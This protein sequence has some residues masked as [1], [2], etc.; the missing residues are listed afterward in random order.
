MAGETALERHT[1]VIHGDHAE[2]RLE[3]GRLTMTKGSATQA[4]PTEVTVPV[5]RVRGVTLEAPSRGAPGWLHVSVVGGSPPPPTSLAA[6]GDPYTVP[7]G[8]RATGPAKRLVRMVQRHVRARGLPPEA[9]S[10]GR[11]SGV[12]LDPQG[13]LTVKSTPAEVAE[14]PLSSLGHASQTDR[15]EF[16]QQL[17]ELA[18]LH[19]TGALTDE[20]FRRAKQRLIGP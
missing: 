20:E 3:D 16:V 4:T 17:G 12:V 14:G 13:P 5:E 10:V 2:L 18:D 9:P 19:A 11:S 7:V 8:S 6:A 1:V 15:V